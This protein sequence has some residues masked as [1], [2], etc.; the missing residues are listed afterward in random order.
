MGRK[1]IIDQDQILRIIHHWLVHRGMAPTIEELRQA[2]GV[3]S[4]STVLRCLLELEQNG[5]IERWPGSRGL[6]LLKGP[7]TQLVTRP[8]PLVGIVS[9]GPLMF[10][11]G[12]FETWI[13][14]PEK[15]LE[16]SSSQFFLLRISGDSMNRGEVPGGK[17]E[18]GDLAL[19]RQQA[20]AKSGQIVVAIVDGEATVKRLAIGQDFVVL[21]PV[22]TN[23]LHQ[24]IVL[25]RAA[26]LQGVVCRVFKKG[27]EFLTGGD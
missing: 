22:S 23:H 15:M 12:N 17:I 13:R 6:K 2:L 4:T 1:K 11:E 9:A 16:P 21:K 7:A 14:L 26:H 19:I 3:G 20:T 24:P 27:S 8:I 25:D 10:A 18:D 5:F